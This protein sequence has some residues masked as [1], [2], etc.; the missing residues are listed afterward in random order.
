MA[1][2]GVVTDMVEDRQHRLVAAGVSDSGFVLARYRPNGSLD[3]SFTG[4]RHPAPGVVDTELS[5]GGAYG[6]ALQSHGKIVVAGANSMLRESSGVVLARYLADGSLDQEFGRRGL[7]QTRLGRL[8]GAGQAIAVQT[9][10]RIVVGG[11]VGPLRY[12]GLHRRNPSGLLI[13]YLAD[14]SID[15]SFGNHGQLRIRGNHGHSVAITD[16]TILASGKILA[17]GNYGGRFLLARLLPDGRFDPS[18]GDGDGK[19]ATK[20]AATRSAK[21]APR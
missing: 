8:A 3:P 17:A 1:A 7:V 15:R 11:F 5:G 6:I 18:L 9:D 14:G 10:G 16:V 20:I 19:T 2:S 21:R 12:P 4:G 13:R